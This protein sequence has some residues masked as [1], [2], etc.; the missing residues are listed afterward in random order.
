MN[1]A[2]RRFL[3]LVLLASALT[4]HPADAAE[5]AQALLQRGLAA[6]EKGEYGQAAAD[7]G[8]VIAQ[9]Y[10]DPVLHYNLANA[11][12]KTGELGPAI[13]HYRR[14]HALAPR[15]ED[16]TA[17]YHALNGGKWNGMM[18]Q[19]HI[20]YSSWQQPDEQ[21]M[22]EETGYQ[23]YHGF[24]TEQENPGLAFSVVGL[25][26]VVQGRGIRGR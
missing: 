16:I 22:P 18:L 2:L 10:D 4:G 23:S 3:A 9:G 6:Y 11:L 20:G 17:Q 19:T 26:A 7:F 24:A 21:E 14:A 1:G 8:A 12:F 13:W 25:S 5:S 15:D